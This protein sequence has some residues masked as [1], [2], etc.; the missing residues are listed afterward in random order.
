M[1]LIIVA[2]IAVPPIVALSTSG[3]RAIADDRRSFHAAWFATAVLEQIIADAGTQDGEM[4][5]A[6]MDAPG[7]LDDPGAGLRARLEDLVSE[8]ESR[9]MAYEVTIGPALDAAGSP[10]DASDRAATRLVTVEI[11]YTNEL[12]R[13]VRAP[14][15]T[16][17]GA[18]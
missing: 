9:G 17:V 18:A 16:V 10:V 7:Y 15:S 11:V 4:D 8:Y 13:D 12:G 14:L 2:A 6:A 5:L 3:S 1:A